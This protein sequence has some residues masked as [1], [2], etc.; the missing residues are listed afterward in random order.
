MSVAVRVKSRVLYRSSRSFLLRALR[1]VVDKGFPS[2]ELS[3]R[4]QLKHFV[5]QK[6]FG[7]N[8]HVPWLVRW[9][10]ICCVPN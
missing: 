3:A 5:V 1:V 2:A 6:I 4:L 8:R 10:A 7:V 9:V